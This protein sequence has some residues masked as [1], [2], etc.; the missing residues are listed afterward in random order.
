MI[1]KTQV[2]KL[3]VAT[4]VIGTMGYLISQNT[5]DT[6][7]NANA[8][9]Q[10]QKLN[11]GHA[12]IFWDSNIHKASSLL[13]DHTSSLIYK[14]YSNQLERANKTSKGKYAI[15]NINVEISSNAI[16]PIFGGGFF[17]GDKLGRIAQLNSQ[18]EAN[19]ILDTDDNP[20]SYFGKDEDGLEIP[21]TTI[22]YIG[23]DRYVVVGGSE[24]VAKDSGCYTIINSKGEV[25]NEFIDTKN[26]PDVA[27]RNFKQLP[28][29]W[30]IK[31]NQHGSMITHVERHESNNGFMLVQKGRA[32]IWYFNNEGAILNNGEPYAW[33][34]E[35]VNDENS[36]IIHSFGNYY[37]H[38]LGNSLQLF[39]ITGNK[40]TL[41]DTIKV[42]DSSNPINDIVNMG[43]SDFDRG[44][45]NILVSSNGTSGVNAGHYA[46]ISFKKDLGTFSNATI[47]KKSLLSFVNDSKEY[48]T[49]SEKGWAFAYNN[50]GFIRKI[51]TNLD[52]HVPS[53]DKEKLS[54]SAIGRD[55]WWYNLNLKDSV[56][57]SNLRKI[58]PDGVGGF[59]AFFDN[60]GIVR[61]DT[62]GQKIDYRSPI[63]GIGDYP[64]FQSHLSNRWADKA[65]FTTF[66]GSA[67][68]IFQIV[69]WKNKYYAIS[70]PYTNGVARMIRLNANMTPDSSFAERSITLS[71]GEKLTKV[72]L[73]DFALSTED[74]DVDEV[75]FIGTSSGNIIAYDF[76][77][78]NLTNKID[79][80]KNISIST[81]DA[82]GVSETNRSISGLQVSHK[83]GNQILYF[84]RQSN[85]YALENGVVTMMNT[86]KHNTAG[87]I[88]IVPVNANDS[89]GG[90]DVQF[91]VVT[92][93]GSMFGFGAGN[94]LIDET[95]VDRWYRFGAAN[96]SNSNP[97]ENTSTYKDAT[98]VL[99]A[100][101][102]SLFIYGLSGKISKVNYQYAGLSGIRGSKDSNFA[103]AGE[104]TAGRILQTTGNGETAEQITS[105][106][107][108]PD[109]SY[110]LG[111]TKGR[112]TRITRNGSFVP[113]FEIDSTNKGKFLFG[114]SGNMTNDAVISQIISDG[115]GYYF[116]VEGKLGR[117]TLINANGE[118][119]LQSGETK[120]ETLA[121]W[122]KGYT[123]PEIDLTNYL[124]QLWFSAP[125]SSAT[126][127]HVLL[128][129]GVKLEYSLNGHEWF[130][131][132]YA[133]NIY[134]GDTVFVRGVQDSTV[135]SSYTF[136]ESLT[137]TS[138]IANN[139]KEVIDGK[140]IFNPAN[141]SID[142][143]SDNLSIWFEYEHPT[144]GVDVDG[145]NFGARNVRVEYNNNG[146]WTPEIPK[147]ITNGDVIELKVSPNANFDDTKYEIINDTQRITVNTLGKTVIDA[148]EY[149]STFVIA[150]GVRNA[151]YTTAT[152]EDIAIENTKFQFSFVGGQFDNNWSDDFPSN[153]LMNGQTVYVRLVGNSN[154]N[155]SAYSLE[156]TER[157]IF[158]NSLEK[159]KIDLSSV[160]NS[161]EI[162]GA[163]AP[164]RQTLTMDQIDDLAI[165]PG[166]SGFTSVEGSWKFKI[167]GHST[168]Y[169]TF[170]EN[171]LNNG[172]KL[173]M[174]F[175]LDQ[176]NTELIKNNELSFFERTITISG[177]TY[178]S[179][180]LSSYW[181]GVKFTGQA[182]SGGA[183]FYENNN[184]LPPFPI[185]IEF[186]HD[187]SVWTTITQSTPL[188]LQN[189]RLVYLRAVAD[190]GF[191][192]DTHI[193]TMASH[194]YIPRNLDKQELDVESKFQAIQITGQVQ[195]TILESYDPAYERT[196]LYYS[197]VKNP[198]RGNMAHWKVA[199]LS[200]ADKMS[201]VNGSIIHYTYYQDTSFDSNNY[202]IVNNRLFKYTVSNLNKGLIDASEYLSDDSFTFARNAAGESEVVTKNIASEIKSQYQYSVDGGLTWLDSLP[203]NLVNGD[204]IAIQVIPSIQHGFDDQSFELVNTFRSSLIISG[205]SKTIVH[206]GDI[207]QSLQ[208][209]TT[210]TAHS[211][212]FIS[213]IDPLL[214]MANDLRYEFAFDNTLNNNTIW[215]SYEDSSY[216]SL[217]QS[218]PLNKLYNGQSYYVRVAGK[219]SFDNL[220]FELVNNIS[221]RKLVS[222]LLKYQISTSTYY[223]SLSVTGSV[224][225]PVYNK[226]ALDSLFTNYLE[227]QYTLDATQSQSTWTSHEIKGIKNGDT[228]YAK[229]APKLNFDSLNFEFDP[230]SAQFTSLII[231]GLSKANIS[232]N[233]VLESI[234][235]HGDS[236]SATIEFS[237]TLENT[238]LSYSQSLTG[239]WTQINSGDTIAGLSNSDVLH[240]KLEG[241]LSSNDW[242]FNYNLVNS[243]IS[244]QVSG[245]NL[246]TYDLSWFINSSNSFFFHAANDVSS[247]G[248]AHSGQ[249][250]IDLTNIKNSPSYSATTG[251]ENYIEF[252][253]KF[254][255]SN[256]YT[257]YK[258]TSKPSKLYNGQK[259][260]IYASLTST[261]QRLFSLSNSVFELQI[262]D[263][264]FDKMSLNA[265]TIAS[266]VRLSGYAGNA[267][268]ILPTTIKGLDVNYSLN[269]NV[270]PGDFEQYPS[271]NIWNGDVL[272]IKINKSSIFDD[273]NYKLVENS[274]NTSDIDEIIKHQTVSTLSKNSL[275][276]TNVLNGIVIERNAM[277][278][279]VSLLSQTFETYLANNNME[280]LFG[281]GNSLPIDSA[282]VSTLPT[283][284]SNRD[285]VWVKVVSTSG[286]DTLNYAIS[287]TYTNNQRTFLIS[288][289]S[290]VQVDFSTYLSSVSFS[291]TA[292]SGTLNFVTSTLPTT[293]ISISQYFMLGYSVNGGQTTYTIPTTLN[294]NDSVFISVLPNATFINSPIIKE[295]YE[296]I[297]TELYISSVDTL[298]K[299]NVDISTL[300]TGHSLMGV[301][302]TQP[303][304]SP[305]LSTIKNFDKFQFL[306]SKTNN[307]NSYSEIMPVMLNGETLYVQ[308]ELIDSNDS[309]NFDLSGSTYSF[310]VNTLSKQLVDISTFWTSIRSGGFT[311]SGEVW[312]EQFED[313]ITL[314]YQINSTIGTANWTSFESTKP[315]T[316]KNGDKIHFRALPNNLFDQLNYQL[317][318]T[319]ITKTITGLLPIF[320]DLT[321]VFKL[322][323]ITGEVNAANLN[324]PSNLNT[325]LPANTTIKYQVSSS[326]ISSDVWT[327]TFSGRGVKNNN[328]LHI[329]VEKAPG[330][331][332]VNYSLINN[333]YTMPVKGLT[334][335]AI[336]VNNFSDKI[337]I[338]GGLNQA[339]LNLN[340]LSNDENELLLQVKNEYAI[341]P[342]DPSKQMEWVTWVSGYQIPGEVQNGQQIQFRFV[343]SISYDPYNFIIDFS[344][345]AV[346]TISNLSNIYDFS[347][348]WSTL[349][350]TGSVF[351]AGL[352]HNTLDPK[353]KL[354]FRVSSYGEGL[355][356]EEWIVARNILKNNDFIKIKVVN[357][358][359]TETGLINN[360]WPPSNSQEGYKITDLAKTKIDAQWYVDEFNADGTYLTPNAKHFEIVMG[361]QLFEMKQHITYK[362][363]ITRA[364]RSSA[365]L[366]QLPQN[367]WNGDKVRLQLVVD[368]IAYDV[369]NFEFINMISTTNHTITQMKSLAIIK[370]DWFASNKF[371]VI[372]N[373]DGEIIINK[374]ELNDEFL[375]VLYSL[376]D[377]EYSDEMPI[378]E[379]TTGTLYIRLAT[380]SDAN[381]R[382]T[383]VDGDESF[384][385]NYSFDS[386][387]KT[388]V[389][390]NKP[391]I[392][393]IIVGLNVVTITL[394]SAM[395]ALIKKR[396]RL[397]EIEEKTREFEK[398]QEETR[399][400]EYYKDYYGE[401]E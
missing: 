230:L 137:K 215:Y 248:I 281:V 67:N 288:G 331:D 146:I 294:N 363:Q 386:E 372:K 387:V 208:V 155:S 216:S 277:G 147:G 299:I 99:D 382:Y 287:S 242:Q 144:A 185:R 217:D 209:D 219:S 187:G 143:D 183:S 148:T 369:H 29:T 334:K 333:E 50:E 349:R 366:D 354:Q 302:N 162:T 142:G 168:I 157:I 127:N 329:K 332:S 298:T 319:E 59:Y 140:I 252:Y 14:E 181:K 290:K 226:P 222:G 21:I 71:A 303:S 323:N 284:L 37:L 258:T 139:L 7:L 96:P 123:R 251:I 268:Y 237:N 274:L 2:A 305:S 269:S 301:S 53:S 220:N 128:P 170:P 63:K 367:L 384:S 60:Y 22:K 207:V 166:I 57:D 317:H 273:L 311:G 256:S 306:Y 262:P 225:A 80:I 194:Q 92:N 374:P 125:E 16:S 223:P 3:F 154:F 85:V 275:S 312:F 224:N 18:G 79:G 394:V 313:Y 38:I 120:T 55:N 340:G 389:E 293:N 351:D 399:Y 338:D 231:G 201:L 175:E 25:S 344:Q 341:V 145:Y 51:N 65:L 82:G 107:P 232:A 381:G 398:Q 8:I 113:G 377:E 236:T 390:Y 39:E 52:F 211:G 364:A 196:K 279:T 350:I 75:L 68:R 42:F 375:N 235:F 321:S 373:S 270:L 4:S 229:L 179:I 243:Q 200:V 186:S 395:I 20:I 379:D 368:P 199:P 40:I 32:E 280:I 101:D 84:S 188:T 221:D 115:Q 328:F 44:L 276:V 227:W 130:D 271:K 272:N 325:L 184:V 58:L 66:T 249:M 380:S 391:L 371:N 318:N 283:N 163:P 156:N 370:N 109:G 106:T 152:S 172:T 247:K 70:N 19:F 304:W 353:F 77:G 362:Y 309:N 326:P 74:G 240:F 180:D 192:I 158:V 316:L 265:E 176:S 296:F 132:I 286:F 161:V 330:F 361:D 297:N 78:F 36:A 289:L 121:R 365:W 193:L 336:N 1:K 93:D 255:N 400:L 320:I 257:V 385:I 95:V 261:G 31:P 88:D 122:H 356:F 190:F 56:V 259:L 263:T 69:P 133:M 41:K 213:S 97:W 90:H 352:T 264:Q 337:S 34:G 149:I 153:I 202:T 35:I 83:D 401:N 118:Q 76:D 98:K 214:P 159:N 345:V 241:D 244:M 388:G 204:D 238:T 134:N 295:N 346:K 164:G 397:L 141:V 327:D 228:L 246:N 254:E 91:L 136:K 197:L 189:G 102:G 173:T 24:T 314:E 210:T 129:R 174:W 308:M 13:S 30:T 17:I 376:D 110:M 33:G 27:K 47:T 15:D 26:E 359:G 278:E 81:D 378:I 355:P 218:N 205:M 393:G 165:L 114:T 292:Y 383:I 73:Q 11:E 348:F 282:F 23:N 167:D 104:K 347:A 6:I 94:V 112:I 310:T 28:T 72:S 339:T 119:V 392:I 322:F 135:E 45:I 357:A 300:L 285:R 86:G 9:Q 266:Q 116:A 324:K 150:G 108:M 335:I 307:F 138:I 64:L 358:D 267:S 62:N 239:T 291:G 343:N 245:L 117:I 160:L 195:Q 151:S 10:L 87:I 198:D 253:Y 12:G 234:K 171:S 124:D 46:K 169:S 43:Q 131:D 126:L 315:T 54:T 260:Q 206:V 89:F 233:V 212:K 177:L 48:I 191:P 61:F 396:H 250:T 105:M 360:I 5:V 203:N 111:M 342:T 178:T 100:G 103:I 182:I 49:A